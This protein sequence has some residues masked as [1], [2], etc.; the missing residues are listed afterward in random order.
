MALTAHS[1]IGAKNRRESRRALIVSVVLHVVVGAGLIRVLLLPGPVRNWLGLGKEA[2]PH[3]EHIQYVA[4]LAAPAP[5]SSASAPHTPPPPHAAP[6]PAGPTVVA[7]PTV[8]PTTI[9]PAPT[10]PAPSTDIEGVGPVAGTG[11]PASGSRLE[12]HDRRV[13]VPPAPPGEGAKPRTLAVQLDSAAHAMVTQHNDSLAMLGPTRKPGD[14]TKEIGGKKWGMDQQYIHLGPISIPNA[15]LAAL[16]LNNFTGNPIAA[17]NERTLNYRQQDIQYQANRAM[18]AEEM[19]KAIKEERLRKEREHEA[20]E[21]KQKEQPQPS[22]Q[23]T[24]PPVATS[25]PPSAT[26]NQ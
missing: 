25:T 18:D 4:T 3:E 12:Y 6:P 22:Q 23:S 16:P 11:G 19:N 1:R 5:P 26:P 20:Q 8:V 10:K 7:Q 9:A 13:W 15:V 17:E 2:K 21:Q 14:W 24:T